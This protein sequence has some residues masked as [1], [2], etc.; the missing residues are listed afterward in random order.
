MLD[1]VLIRNT[2]VA[3]R[4]VIQL[5]TADDRLRIIDS[6]FAGPSVLDGGSQFDTLT[7][8]GNRF[9]FEPELIDWDVVNRDDDNSP[10]DPTV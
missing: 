8:K 7:L 5:G 4:T 6:V 1:D 2:H 9:A 10:L 3:G